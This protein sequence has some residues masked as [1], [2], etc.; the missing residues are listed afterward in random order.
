MSRSEQ[1]LQKFLRRVTIPNSGYTRCCLLQLVTS[2]GSTTLKET[3][4]NAE[5][6][7]DE[8]KILVL[9]AEFFTIAQEDADGHR[10]VTSYCLKAFKGVMQGERSPIF[11]LRAQESEYGDEEALGETEP[12]TKEGLLAQMMRHNEANNRLLAQVFEVQAR[13]TSEDKR[14]LMEQIRHYEDRH[15]ETMLRAEELAN[16]KDS[17]ELA[18]LQAVAAEKRKEELIK[19]LKPLVPVAMAKFKGTPDSAKPGLWLESLKEIMAQT[20]P[21]DMQRIAEILGPKSLALATIYM[22]AHQGEDIPNEQPDKEGH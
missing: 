8:E 7:Y 11:R 5:F 19:M 2:G 3:A 10:G 15:W 1:S 21:E 4:L 13:S 6:G 16:E 12:A 18:K 17:R 9:V 14:T 22:D 20:T